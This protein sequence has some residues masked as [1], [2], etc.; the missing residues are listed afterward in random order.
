[1]KKLFE[2]A[3]RNGVELHV[4]YSDYSDTFTVTVVKDFLKKDVTFSNAFY[5]A[6]VDEFDAISMLI[7]DAINELNRLMASEVSLRE[8]EKEKE[9]EN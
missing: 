8:K 3:K 4:K 2:L 6:V 9:N 1:M 5:E 7:V